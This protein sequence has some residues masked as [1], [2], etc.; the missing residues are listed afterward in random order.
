MERKR[1]FNLL[2]TTILGVIVI[3]ELISR[4]FF[5]AIT[6]INGNLKIANRIIEYFAFTGVIIFSLMFFRTGKYLMT[7]LVFILISI[8]IINSFFEIYPV[9]TTT[10]PVDIL[11]LHTNKDGTKLVVRERL[12]AKTSEAIRDTVLVEDNMIWRKIIEPKS[13]TTNR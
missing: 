11:V 10:Q 2:V 9:D 3:M 6:F 5:P 13:H 12:N 7:P 4:I 1:I 8:F